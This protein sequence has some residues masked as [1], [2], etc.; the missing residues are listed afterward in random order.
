MNI[1]V[2]G[3]SIA[4][5]AT[6]LAVAPAGAQTAPELVL[7]NGKILTPS[8]SAQALGV[9]DGR[10]VAIGDN[11]SVRTK[12]GR[13]AEVIDLKGKTVMPGMYDMHVHPA[14]GGMMLAQCTFPQGSPPDRILSAVAGCARQ[15]RPGEWIV[16]GQWAASSFG[17]REPHRQMLD[18]AAPSNPVLLSD[19]SGHSAWVNSAALKASGITRE[20]K[21]PPNGRI[22]RDGDGEPTGVLRE[23]ASFMVRRKIPQPTADETKAGL[24]RATDLMLS[25]GITG[26]TDASVN[27]DRLETYLS[28]NRNGEIRQRTRLCVSPLFEGDST[29]FE[30]FLS[31]RK[32]QSAGTLQVDC[33]KLMMDGVPTESHTAAMLEPYEHGPGVEPTRGMLM[34]PAEKL[35][36]MVIRFDKEGLTVKFHSAGDWAVRA[37]LDAIAAARKANGPNGPTHD[38]GH[39]TFVSPTDL[40]RA[41]SLRATLEFS[42][43]LWSP[44]PINDDIIKATGNE[45][46]KRVWPVREGINSGALVVVGSDWAVVPSVSPWIGLETL[47]T[48]KA[49]GGARPGESYGPGEAITV[50]EAIRLFTVNGAKQMGLGTEVGALEVGKLADFIII[51]RNPLEVPVTEIHSTVV[52][53]V[54]INGRKVFQRVAD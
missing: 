43:Y 12:A 39:L 28:M 37:A 48:R 27:G 51:D 42:P 19:I 34:I 23:T 17:D 21:D 13:N 33:I 20:T 9:R 11:T 22:E 1:V 49:V 36:P 24:K 45:R 16:G 29:T 7:I 14:M 50:K 46:I 41:K 15:K 6:S 26:Y 52:E 4:V 53:Q 32:R 31:N 18:Q 5:I 35:H 10:I 8:A 25:F 54:Y 40:T 47:V 2:S 44:S 30:R 38:P 3:W